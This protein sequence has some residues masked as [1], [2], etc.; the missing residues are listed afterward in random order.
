[1][2]SGNLMVHLLVWPADV[3]DLDVGILTSRNQTR[4]IEP[5]NVRDLTLVVGVPDDAVLVRRLHR[6]EDDVGVQPSRGHVHRVGSPSHTVHLGDMGQSQEL[7]S[8]K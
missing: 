4:V 3:P 5:G 6:P 2:H 1:V 8:N 7:Y